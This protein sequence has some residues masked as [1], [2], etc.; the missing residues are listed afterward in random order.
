VFEELELAVWPPQPATHTLPFQSRAAVPLVAPTAQDATP[1]WALTP[2]P[3]PWKPPSR[4]EPVAPIFGGAATHQLAGDSVQARASGGVARCACVGTT[5]DAARLVLPSVS[6]AGAARLARTAF[7]CFGLWWRIV[8]PLDRF[9]RPRLGDSVGRIAAVA[10]R[11]CDTATPRTLFA[12]LLLPSQ[13]L[14]TRRATR[15]LTRTPPG[16]CA[17]R[18]AP[19][20]GTF[21][22]ILA[23][24][25]VFLEDCEFVFAARVC[26][27]TTTGVCL[28]RV[29]V[30]AAVAPCVVRALSWFGNFPFRS[31][32]CGASPVSWWRYHAYCALIRRAIPRW[33]LSLTFS[34]FFHSP[35]MSSPFFLCI[36][37]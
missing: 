12:C 28:A 5:V 20:S 37:A 15:P 7:L 33:C 11:R 29:V 27:S 30:E 25:C 14:T 36:A 18:A 21:G 1:Q 3:P 9:L 31:G 22:F 34:A 26:E 8:L 16:Y 4:G 6:L 23:F 10:C 17:P 35:R 13:W 19:F 24:A 32:V 2:H